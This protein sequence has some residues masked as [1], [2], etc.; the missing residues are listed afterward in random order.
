MYRSAERNR[1]N[2]QHSELRLVIDPPFEAVHDELSAAYYDGE[3][4]RR[5]GVLDKATFDKLHALIFHRRHNAFH[6][7]NLLRP[8]AQRIPAREY[9]WANATGTKLLTDEADAYIAAR[10]AEG[11][12][13]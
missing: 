3:P 7:A 9:N 8:L 4:F 13:L 6:A 11:L 1:E 5:F 10:R 12:E 2:I